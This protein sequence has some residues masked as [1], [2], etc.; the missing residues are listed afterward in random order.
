ARATS[1]AGR[2]KF[3]VPLKRTARRVLADR[4]AMSLTA[5]VSVIAPGRD[6]FA[7]TRGVVMSNGAGS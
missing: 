2:V 6:A 7:R 4:E 5:K 1:A 3:T